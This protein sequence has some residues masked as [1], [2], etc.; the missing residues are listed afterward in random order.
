MTNTTIKTNQAGS[1]SGEDKKNILEIKEQNHTKVVDAPKL[2]KVPM[3]DSISRTPKTKINFGEKSEEKGA[4]G[5][6]EEAIK[7][8]LIDKER[9]ES[10]TEKSQI[11]QITS[12]TSATPTTSGQ[13]GTINQAKENSVTNEKKEPEPKINTEK[14]A[15]EITKKIE[16]EITKNKEAINQG[17]TKNI[18][19]GKNGQR[20]PNTPQSNISS[21]KEIPPAQQSIQQPPRKKMG[22]GPNGK[23]TEQQ[24]GQINREE[25]DKKTS[26]AKNNSATKKNL[27]AKIAPWGAGAIIGGGTISA[28]WFS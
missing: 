22:Q 6:L 1:G 5:F 15:K 24:P 10:S 8:E 11:P 25:K 12:G 27:L 3:E 4:H 18:L 13:A 7:R 14:L 28:M 26:S 9:I 20:Q 19:E 16:E 17:T 23:A 21:S 2:A